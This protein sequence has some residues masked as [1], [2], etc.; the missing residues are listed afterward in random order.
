MPGDLDLARLVDLNP[1]LMPCTA[2]H[3]ANAAA[4][5]FASNY[6]DTHAAPLAIQED[7]KSPILVSVKCPTVTESMRKS[8]HDLQ[9]AAEHGACGIALL[10]M[11]QEHGLRFAFQAQKGE[12]FDYW[13][14]SASEDEFNFLRE[15]ARLEVSGLAQCKGTNCVKYRLNQKVKQ[16]K[17]SSLRTFAAVISFYG[18]SLK[19]EMGFR[20]VHG[21]T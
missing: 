4:V 20:R 3:Y 15:S 8:H 2:Q 5:S 9:Y 13:L 14:E 6:L 11:A 10:Y 1:E 17:P 16:P 12:G 18:L 7:D 19:G 21:H